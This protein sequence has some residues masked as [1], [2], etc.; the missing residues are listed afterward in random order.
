MAILQ[1]ANYSRDQMANARLIINSESIGRKW[2]ERKL[3]YHNRK[4]VIQGSDS[5]IP[6]V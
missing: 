2:T 4:G 1:P 5:F 6:R 3:N